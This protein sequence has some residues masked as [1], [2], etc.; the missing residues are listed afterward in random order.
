[1]LMDKEVLLEV[2]PEKEEKENKK[3]FKI[4]SGSTIWK[5]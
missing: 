5:T 2:V 3:G 4:K 1:M